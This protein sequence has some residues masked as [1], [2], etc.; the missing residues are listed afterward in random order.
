MMS[1][2]SWNVRGLCARPKRSSLRKLIAKNN[3]SFV[4]IQETK[5]VDIN[6]K[7]MRTF[8]KEN[9]LQ[10][11]CSPSI[12]NSGGITSIWISSYFE[13]SNSKISQHWIAISGK[14]LPHKFE[15][16][17][18]NIY[19]P[20]DVASRAAVWMEIIDFQRNN[21]IPCL[22]I[23][24]FNE[25]LKETDRG[26]LFFLSQTGSNDFKNFVQELHLL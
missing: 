17:L 7:M 2:I 24:D 9:D 4:F 26:S 1:I 20:C 22:V 13:V 15:C 18:I 19:N 10:W 21:P 23:G 6:K 16:T 25:I 5:M 11:V 12:G 14:I 3:P 8:W